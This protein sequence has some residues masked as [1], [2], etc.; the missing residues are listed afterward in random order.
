MAFV[1][2]AHAQTGSFWAAFAA[3]HDDAR[4]SF[5]AAVVSERNAFLAAVDAARK[6]V[7][8]AAYADWGGELE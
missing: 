2:R 4:E 7:F 3:A 6:E 5:C 8:C 1:E